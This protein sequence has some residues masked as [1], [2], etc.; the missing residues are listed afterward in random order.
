MAQYPGATAE[1]T[2]PAPQAPA[3]KGA[4]EAL[5]LKGGDLLKLGLAGG[6]G[7]YGMSQAQGAAKQGQAQVQAARPEDGARLQE[8]FNELLSG[9]FDVEPVAVEGDE[10]ADDAPQKRVLRPEPEAPKLHKV[11]AQAG[12]GSRRDMEQMILEGRI[13]VNGEPAHIGQRISFGDQIRVGGKQ[14]KV[15]ISPP[16]ARVLAYHKPVGEV[17]THDDPQNRL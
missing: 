5:G 11:L 7:L 15:R 14:I 1:L 9:E 17:V 8:V 16:P 13:T 10:N 12:V 3:G 4:L 6:M 2:A